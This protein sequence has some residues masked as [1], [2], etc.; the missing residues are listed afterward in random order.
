MTEESLQ[1]Y[2]YVPAHTESSRE[3]A[4]ATVY[5]TLLVIRHKQIYLRTEQAYPCLVA[6]VSG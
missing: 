5:V 1:I 6:H 2:V 4:V 3:G